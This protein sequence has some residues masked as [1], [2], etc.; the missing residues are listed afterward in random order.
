M[1]SSET[2]HCLVLTVV[3]IKINCFLFPAAED[4]AHAVV[5]LLSDKSDMITG[6]AL[7]VDGGMLVT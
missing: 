1:L 4:I 6:T 7:S 5:F 2:A 3:L